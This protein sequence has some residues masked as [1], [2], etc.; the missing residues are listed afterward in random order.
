MSTDYRRERE[1]GDRR[2]GRDDRTHVFCSC[3]HVE[4][5][6]VHVIWFDT[7]LHR[8]VQ[9]E[10]SVST[11]SHMFQTLKLTCSNAFLTWIEC[12]FMF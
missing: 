4:A 8:S 11:C 12:I 3:I 7:I 5:C 1:A 10:A 6:L 2:K 9:V